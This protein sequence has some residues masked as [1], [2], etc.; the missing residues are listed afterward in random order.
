M[1]RQIQLRP[2]FLALVLFPPADQVP[3]DERPVQAA[4][5]AD[6]NVRRVDIE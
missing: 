6:A 1:L 4:E 5:V 2:F 3:I